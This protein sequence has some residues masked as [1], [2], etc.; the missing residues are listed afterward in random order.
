MPYDR[1]L[2]LQL[3]ADLMERPGD[4]PKH[5]SALGFIGLGAV[6]Y[7]NT[8]IL[9]GMADE[10]DDCV[11][12]LTSGMLGV[13]VACARCH[14]HKFDPFPTQDYYSLAG[15]FNSIKLAPV[16][17]VSRETVAAYESAKLLATEADKKLRDAFQIEKDRVALLKADA[18]GAYMLAAWTF[19]AR[20][21]SKPPTTIDEVAK[22]ASLD[23]EILLRTG[24]YLNRT[25]MANIL[26]DWVKNKPRLD[27]PV[28]PTDETRQ[29][30]ADFVKTVKENLA[31]P[32]LKRNLDLQKDLFEDKGVFA[33]T[34][35]EALA[36]AGEAKKKE[37]LALKAI[38]A[39][40]AAKVPP[41][42]P[43]ANGVVEGKPADMKVYVRG[44]P[45]KLGE[46][47]P[48]RFLRI[49]AGDSPLTFKQGSGRLELAE[50][51]ADPK[52][53]LT[54]R[55]IVNRIWQ[56]HF[57]R[58]IVATPSNFG[59]LGERPTHPELLD[60]LASQLVKQGWSLKKVHREIMLSDAYRRSAEGS[61][62]S[63]EV[64]PDNLLLTHMNRRRIMVESWRD[65]L[66]AISGGLDFTMG[67]NSTNLDDVKNLRRTVYGK[68]SRYNL[69]QLLR[70]FDFPDPNITSDRRS[71]TTVP[72]QL[73][74]VMN[75]PFF[76]AQ[77]KALA[78]RFDRESDSA[79]KVKLAYALVFARDPRPAEIELGVRYLDRI[80][81]PESAVKNQL[82][83]S[84]RFAQS[85]LASNEF[86]YV[87]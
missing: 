26:A 87:D 3:A 69:S 62:K 67:G 82:S 22:S 80:D 29:A 15:I 65:A 40:L 35:Q 2:K 63:F 13:T 61:A 45:Y 8:D 10:L 1:F 64:D 32:R 37:I 52:N 75:S 59:L 71:E 34:E 7:K 41:E 9:R 17:V 74:F 53:P 25:A 55:V 16:P 42:L 54:A 33:V 50:A 6:Y 36:D 70:L 39:E 81:A 77:A 12:T 51:I 48:R 44:N 14:D 20:K 56:Q 60:Y 58:G 24:G 27:G 85:L 79:A 57:G 83:R 86:L 21:L 76:I 43:M 4:D 28:E 31:K 30:A 23:K 78:G 68:V 11:D 73:L 49:V 66:L 72:Q 18:I 5:R 47:A 19:E 84:E 46:V 38:A